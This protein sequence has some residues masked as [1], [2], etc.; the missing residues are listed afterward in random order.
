MADGTLDISVVSA[1]EYARDARALSAASGSRDLLRRPGAERHAVLATRPRDELGGRRVIVS[2]SSMTSVA[3]LELLFENVWHARPEFVPGDAEMS[4]IARVRQRAARGA[5]GDRRRGAVLRGEAR[6]RRESHATG[7]PSYPYR[8][9][10]RSRRGRR[11]RGCRSCSPSGS[12]SA[13]HRSPKR[14]ASH[15]SAD[16]V[17]QL[18]AGSTSTSWPD[19]RR[20]VTGVSRSPCVTSTCR[21]WTTA[22]RTSTSPG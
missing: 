6:P 9:R 21:A 17:A 11:G 19:R 5:A 10:S 1:V 2:R 8:L 20:P 18:G 22:S 7:L 3:L 16:H 4:D 12:R 14:S 13:R 15:A